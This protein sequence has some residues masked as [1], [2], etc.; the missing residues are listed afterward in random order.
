MAWKSSARG[1]IVG[2]SSA[3]L[4]LQ[5]ML[6]PVLH[7]MMLAVN[8]LGFTGL[9]IDLFENLKVVPEWHAVNLNITF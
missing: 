8:A 2:L 5:H 7:T 1:E 6:Q 3:K 4:C 9:T